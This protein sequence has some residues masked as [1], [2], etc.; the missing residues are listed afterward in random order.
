MIFTY[1][2]YDCVSGKTKDQ[3]KNYYNQEDNSLIIKLIQPL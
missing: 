1:K 2:S 3:L